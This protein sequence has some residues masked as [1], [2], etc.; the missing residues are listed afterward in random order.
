MKQLRSVALLITAL[1]I[2]VIGCWDFGFG[3]DEETT[4]PTPSQVNRARAEMYLKNTANITALGYK[5]AGSGIDDAIWFKFQTDA[6]DLAQV[7]DTTVVDP[8]RFT[9]NA[10]L[11][12]LKEVEW[13]D[14]KGK[15]LFG[16]QVALP[17]ARFMAIG[18]EKTQD[19]YII[20]IF[21]HA[22]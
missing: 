20:Y 5:L 3:V 17:N 16:G 8:T 2:G 22:T 6:T 11:T 21:W 13:W 12:T 4:M 7:F 1:L 14:V 9:E 19:G 18:A 10:N 15:N